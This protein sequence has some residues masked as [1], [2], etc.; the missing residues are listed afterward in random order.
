MIGL[1]FPRLPKSTVIIAVHKLVNVLPD[2]LLYRIGNIRSFVVYGIS[3]F[4]HVYQAGS[5]LVQTPSAGD[6]FV[7]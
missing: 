4:E 2:L 6:A 3:A 1:P 7:R 5:K